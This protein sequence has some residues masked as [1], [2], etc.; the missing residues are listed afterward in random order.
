MT[1]DCLDNCFG[2]IFVF[3]T[4][5]KL[6]K[7]LIYLQEY[8]MFIFGTPNPRLASIIKELLY[9]FLN[10]KACQVIYLCGV[11]D[12]FA[13]IFVQK[14]FYFFVLFLIKKFKR[15]NIKYFF[16]SRLLNFVFRKIKFV[17][18]IEFLR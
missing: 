8:L 12:F 16:S 18:F 5:I 15:Y 4:T 7:K 6:R 13:H 17:L 3:C 14:I 9:F 11:K 1:F 10:F 2:N